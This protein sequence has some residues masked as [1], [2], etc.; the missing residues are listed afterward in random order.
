MLNTFHASRVISRTRCFTSEIGCAVP[1]RPPN[2]GIE[3]NARSG[4][5]RRVASGQLLWQRFEDFEVRALFQ[6]CTFSAAPARTPQMPPEPLLTKLSDMYEPLT[7]P[8]SGQYPRYCFSRLGGPCGPK[9][10]LKEHESRNVATYDHARIRL[11]S[12]FFGHPLD[13]EKCALTR[14]LAAC[15]GGV[16][17]NLG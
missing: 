14:I 10:S 2:Q 16:P 3:R 5:C 17:R 12:L 11:S 4:L 13:L 9:F 6:S 8:R 7:M 1:S 15:C